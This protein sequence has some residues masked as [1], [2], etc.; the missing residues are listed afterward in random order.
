[1]PPN[2]PPEAVQEHEDPSC[3][4]ALTPEEKEEIYCRAKRRARAKLAFGIHLVVFVAVMGLLTLINMV[5]TP[6]TWWAIW[7]LFSWG[8]VL[9]LHWL[10]GIRLLDFYKTLQE[11]EIAREIERV[12]GE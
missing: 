1:M 11:K 5:A 4:E 6:G 12:M 9:L 8:M 3:Y 10:F 7:P 2:H